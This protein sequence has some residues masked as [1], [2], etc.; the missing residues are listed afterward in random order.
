M[1]RPYFRRRDSAP[2]SYTPLEVA[3]R[4]N[5]P[6]A[7]GAGQRIGI[8]ELGGGFQQSDLDAAFALYGVRGVNPPT[9]VSVDG[10]VNV[11]GG[12]PNGADGE[13]ELDVEIICSLC[14]DADVRVYFAPNTNQGF[15]DAIAQATAD[16]CN[17]L[18]ISWGA[19]ENEW[20][21]GIGLMEMAL[22]AAQKSGIIVCA[23][24][25]DAGSGDGESGEHVD[26]PASSWH[27]IGCGGTTLGNNSEV[28]WDDGQGGGSS[29]G[30]ES[31]LFPLQAWEKGLYLTANA[32]HIIPLAKRGVPDVA[33]NA[34]P[35]TGYIVV[36]DGQQ[37]IIGGT[38][39]VAPLWTALLARLAEIKGSPLDAL[40]IRR[41]LYAN[42]G[43]FNLITKGSNGY[44]DAS[45]NGSW[46]GCTGLGSP[47]GT[48]LANL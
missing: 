30:G 9:A 43:G 36:I 29:G 48:K 3:A 41:N 31:A 34:D 39:A 5:F 14:P 23:A 46:S 11:P 20:G 38:S 26:Y 45:A 19:P 4:Y 44:Y 2:T 17:F 6:N 47:I 35:D 13:V 32:N 10:A 40:W 15:A 25:G 24:S 7:T 42:K 37:G 21:N 12:D 33:G 27:V 18:S 22:I 28:V 1:I 8:I 16:K